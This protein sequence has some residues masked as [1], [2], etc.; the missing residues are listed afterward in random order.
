VLIHPL[1]AANAHR[2]RKGHLVLF[3][4][5]LVGNAG[6]A[7]TPIGNPP[8]YMGF[9]E[10][11][12]F[13]WPLRHLGPPLAILAALL[14]ALFHAVD[15]RLARREPAAP[16]REPLH[17]R[18]WHNAALIV[19]VVATV[20]LQARIGG[21]L[22]LAGQSVP[23][24]RVAAVL[25]FL[26]VTGV[27]ILTTP[28]AVHRGND[29]SWHPMAE[30]ALLFAAILI[31]IAPVLR[32]LEAGRAGPFAPVL[33]LLQDGQGRPLPGAFFWLTGLLS[34]FLDNAQTYLVFLGLAEIRPDALHVAPSVV[35]QA[36]SA[37]AVFFGALTY[38]GN[39]PNMMVRAIAAHRGVRMPGFF[40]F[41]AIAG[42]VLLPLFAVLTALFFR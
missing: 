35:L 37:G 30:V 28:R 6:G 12:P 11:V 38:I 24:G 2:T 29:F 8:L 21:T 9:L 1:I 19:I 10:G 15:R 36:V 7:L 31:T 23:T 3:F 16:S 17:V 40:A 18:G 34:A 25:V 5:I 13:F 39:A 26:A 33:A 20:L 27:S 41:T 4:I 22:T 32:M 14:L 42:E